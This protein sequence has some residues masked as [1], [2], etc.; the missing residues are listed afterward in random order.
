MH[1]CSFSVPSF[2]VMVAL[3]R[4]DDSDFLQS[5]LSEPS[6]PLRSS[7]ADLQASVVLS[8]TQAMSA[9][10]IALPIFF[11]A[12]FIIF[13]NASLHSSEGSAS[14]RRGT[15][16][17]PELAACFLKVSSSRV[18]GARPS[19]SSALARMTSSTLAHGPWAGAAAAGAGR[20]AAAAARPSA[21]MASAAR[22]ARRRQGRPACGAPSLS[23]S[24]RSL[25]STS[26]GTA[27]N[28]TA[29]MALERLIR[30]RAGQ[31]L[32]S[33]TWGASAA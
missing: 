22:A 5:S 6:S 29:D 10:K 7:C 9:L 4:S 33:S 19:S 17:T 25:G 27:A 30:L 15:W 31:K 18:V 26:L 21:P 23:S 14:C 12:A 24:S 1:A 3:H 11:R 28:A 20:K 32:L 16:R 2:V 13:M 8:A